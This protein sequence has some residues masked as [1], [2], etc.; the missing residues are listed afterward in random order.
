M[1]V[2]ILDSG[3]GK[4]KDTFWITAFYEQPKS[5]LWLSQF[6][7]DFL[8]FGIWIWTQ[9]CQLYTFQSV[10]TSH[11]VRDMSQVSCLWFYVLQSSIYT[12]LFDMSV[13][14]KVRTWN[15][16]IDLKLSP[17]PQ[18]S[19]PFLI[20][21]HPLLLHPSRQAGLEPTPLAFLRLKKNIISHIFPNIHS[22]TFL[23]LNLTSQA[24]SLWQ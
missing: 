7:L 14:V 23:F 10:D 5:K 8:E 13:S 21:E 3:L 9:S 19:E 2:E 1:L 22:C 11:I 4:T 16:S 24:F 15:E 6:R 12:A 17:T 20:I 18:K